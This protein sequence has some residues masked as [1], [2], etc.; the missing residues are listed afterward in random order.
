M[1]DQHVYV[2]ASG[3]HA[4]YR[5]HCAVTDQQHA[6]VAVA[7]MN[8][9]DPGS[10]YFI[11]EVPLIEAHRMPYRRT[12]YY[13]Y[14]SRKVLA[15]SEQ[16][17]VS[18]AERWYWETFPAVVE[19]QQPSGPPTAGFRGLDY[20]QVLGAANDFIDLHRASTEAPK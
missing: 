15:G 13:A 2:I 16:L 3:D 9:Q 20:E 6:E 11:D 4:D 17:Q 1:A 14:V 12:V 18:S 5:V 8:N 10:G 7:V 19:H